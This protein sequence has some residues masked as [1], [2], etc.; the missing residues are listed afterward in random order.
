MPILQKVKIDQQLGRAPA[1]HVRFF[2]ALWTIYC[3]RVSIG[4]DRSQHHLQAVLADRVAACKDPRNHFGR[5]VVLEADWASRGFWPARSHRLR[6]IFRL[7]EG[8]LRPRNAFGCLRLSLPSS[9][10]ERRLRFSFAL[11]ARPCLDPSR[12]TLPAH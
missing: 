7:L 5:V 3:L 6:L 4:D 8:C 2:P 11:R 12:S 10:G 9:R 1:G